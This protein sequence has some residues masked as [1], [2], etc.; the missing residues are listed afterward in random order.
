MS[1]TKSTRRETKE[2]M[3]MFTVMKDEVGVEKRRKYR[4]ETVL[5]QQY[6]FI[7]LH[8]I[9][10]LA[11]ER[12]EAVAPTLQRK[13]TVRLAAP[14]PKVAA[15]ADDEE[16][17]AADGEA[18]A[19]VGEGDDDGKASAMASGDVDTLRK[20]LE[21]RPDDAD[22]HFTLGYTLVHVQAKLRDGLRYL[23]SAVELNGESDEFLGELGLVLYRLERYEEAT[24]YLERA[25]AVAPRNATHLVNAGNVRAKQ[26]EDEAALVAYEKA[27]AVDESSAVGWRNIASVNHR[28]QRFGAARS[29]MERVLSLEPESADAHR[30]MGEV[31]LSL[32]DLEAAEAALTTSLRLEPGSALAHET[33]GR[34]YDRAGDRDA[35][36]LREYQTAVKA[37]PTNAPVFTAIGFLLLQTASYDEA[38]TALRTAIRLDNTSFSA[39]NHL[40]VIL[41]K[42]GQQE[43][44]LA[45]FE[46]A[47][48]LAENVTAET[49]MA[50]RNALR[51][52]AT[53]HTNVAHI[54]DDLGRHEDA[55]DHL[56]EALLYDADSPTILAKLGAAHV[57]AGNLAEGIAKFELCL[58]YAPEDVQTFYNL[59]AAQANSG[60]IPGA[61]ATCRRGVAV[62]SDFGPLAQMH[63]MLEPHA[64]KRGLV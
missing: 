48:S 13:S 61:W 41:S 39:H 27:V 25:S 56:T 12:N 5:R 47:I 20:A 63:S 6:A 62:R 51:T 64:K 50:K 28:L 32:G 18:E 26:G 2:L 17:A 38:E 60:D 45:E 36:A 7:R 8:R 11:V 30:K 40:G 1:M 33:L 35:D 34:V 42:R 59:A 22:L 16:R 49:D 37:D 52:L 4:L 15:A 24:R 57:H 54:L 58:E 53:A 23:K 31:Q 19:A 9:A 21:E 10:R 46:R 29:A 3:R 55:I 44:A 43:P 14:P